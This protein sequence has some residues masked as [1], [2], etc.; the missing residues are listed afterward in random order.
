MIG[1]LKSI[2][3]GNRL[4]QKIFLYNGVVIMSEGLFW[5]NF[6]GFLFYFTQKHWG[7]IRLDPETY[8]VNVAPVSLNLWDGLILNLVFLLVSTL[9][10]LIPTLIIS[11]IRP[12]RVL[13]F[14]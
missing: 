2:G 5:G 14:R 13:R 4:I 3:A 7:W 8:Y 1:L 9:L 6:L 10:L 12:S 11:S